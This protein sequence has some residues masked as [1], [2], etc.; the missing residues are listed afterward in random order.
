MRHTAHVLD[1]PIADSELVL[2]PDGSVYHLK[3]HPQ[4]IADT[5]ILVGDPGRV[6]RVSERFDAMEEQVSNREFVTHTGRLGNRRLTVM[7]SG[8]GTDNIDIVVNELDALVNIDLASRTPLQHTRSLNLIRIGTSGSLQESLP[9][10][11]FI[12]SS[13][14]IGLDGVLGFYAFEGSDEE[15]ELLSAFMQHTR[16]PQGINAPYAVAGDNQLIA[17]LRGDHPQGITMTANGFYAPQGRRLRIAPA[18]PDLNSRFESFA[19]RGLA[20]TNYEMET[21]ALYG[22]SSLMGHR[23]CTA[24]AII[25]NRYR[26]EYS[27]DYKITVDRLIDHVLQAI[28]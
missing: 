5:I 26:K 14:S 10:D 24:C 11:S 21:S 3:L 18:I 8:I 27:R 28:G 17:K 1:T 19:W 12:F 9:V 16:W 15:E 22:L 13:H 4:Q 7:S 23:A 6:A 25:A 2:N 20:I